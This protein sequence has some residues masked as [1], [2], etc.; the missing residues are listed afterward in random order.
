MIKRLKKWVFALVIVFTPFFFIS[1]TYSAH[2]TSP[3]CVKDPN[4]PGCTSQN[5]GVSGGGQSQTSN[6]SMGTISQNAQLFDNPKA[7]VGNYMFDSDGWQGNFDPVYWGA[8]I[9]FV[10]SVS[11]M[12]AA[13]NFFKTGYAVNGL[14]GM[15]DI[16]LKIL[17]S[18]YQQVAV[19]LIPLA[20][21]TLIGVF[22]WFGF[23][24][25][26]LPNVFSRVVKVAGAFILVVVISSPAVATSGVIQKI[27][28]F[29]GAIGNF[30]GGIVETVVSSATGA[31]A[32]GTNSLIENAWD[33]LVL[34]EWI[35]GEEGA[36]YDTSGTQVVG[37]Q[38]STAAWR[39]ILGYPLEASVRNQVVGK[40]QNSP[41]GSVAFS[42]GNRIV[43]AVEA[44]LGNL[45][46][47]LYFFVMGAIMIFARLAFL[48]LVAAGAII[49]P[50]ELFPVTRANTLTLR[51]VQYM[52][53]SLFLIFFVSAYSS[54]LFGITQI[55][56]TMAQDLSGAKGVASAFASSSTFFWQ[57]IVYIA[58]IIVAWWI[59]RKMKPMQKIRTATEKAAKQGLPLGWGKRLTAESRRAK[60]WERNSGSR[61]KSSKERNAE[62]KSS[63][64]RRAAEG[65]RDAKSLGR[66][67]AAL[68]HQNDLRDFD[69]ND[70][71]GFPPPADDFESR[72]TG[73]TVEPGERED[74]SFSEWAFEPDRGE[75]RIDGEI[76][77][78]LEQGG[79][80][81][82]SPLHPSMRPPSNNSAAEFDEPNP[83]DQGAPT[84]EWA[85]TD[86]KEDREQREERWATRDAPEQTE[87][88]ARTSEEPQWL[89]PAQESQE[90]RGELDHDVPIHRFAP[91]GRSQRGE[92]GANKPPV[93]RSLPASSDKQSNNK[94][95]VDTVA[96]W[97]ARLSKVTHAMTAVKTL[98]EPDRAMDAMVGVTLGLASRKVADTGKGAAFHLIRKIA[99]QRAELDYEPQAPKRVRRQ[100]N[101]ATVK[102]RKKVEST[103]PDR[104][105]V[106]A[107]HRTLEDMGD[108]AQESV[109]PTRQTEPLK[110]RPSGIPAAIPG[111]NP[112]PPLRER[113]ILRR[114][115]QGTARSSDTTRRPMTMRQRGLKA[116]NLPMGKRSAHQRVQRVARILK[117]TETNPD[118]PSLR[119]KGSSLSD[120]I[121]GGGDR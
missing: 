62:K 106:H 4:A 12:D 45:G 79:R 46:A 19:P 23:I 71:F 90:K 82:P 86:G 40:L 9:I 56:H 84:G 99:A 8:N 16:V 34:Q 32:S 61:G 87:P 83:T 120:R 13:L 55:I 36:N 38:D 88:L 115:A 6:T 17:H 50:L 116:E 97:E 78:Q 109:N 91:T 39:G 37:L 54:V 58:A 43:I 60:P 85:L 68:R 28:A 52:A 117:A 35:A 48:I 96:K 31:K 26:D 107:F 7:P 101:P 29:P 119:R 63:L 103:P 70:D 111:E 81:M 77:R 92:S 114:E 66:L 72:V 18:A 49:L 98:A 1:Y 24:K 105:Y 64:I 15:T 21:L 53:M 3:I 104:S 42:S 41:T 59:Y 10:T 75:H 11:M 95:Q 65:V 33:D 102:A 2:A 27:G 73:E 44:F 14:N 22:I 25:K 80:I 118:R 74:R 113:P 57:G 89:T 100:T 30:A 94:P 110:Q 69:L 112:V 76:P 67:D 51:W 93:R 20:V 108:A 5:S 121:F 47:I